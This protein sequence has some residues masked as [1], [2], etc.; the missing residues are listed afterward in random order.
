MIRDNSSSVVFAS[1]PKTSF[2]LAASPSKTS[3]SAGRK[4]LGSI[5]MYSS[6]FLRIQD[7]TVQ[8]PNGRNHKR[9]PFVWWPSRSHQ[10]HHVGA[11]ATS[12]PGT[13]GH[14]PQSRLASRLPRINFICR[15]AL[16][17]PA[18]LMIFLVT[19]VSPRRYESWL[20]KIPLD[21]NKS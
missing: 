18:A 11:F 3:T 10:T 6:Y 15:P 19:D 16:I 21:A 5:S 12:P 13:R 1:Q 14:T 7:P 17:L 9:R 4:Q 2:V 8:K 20:N